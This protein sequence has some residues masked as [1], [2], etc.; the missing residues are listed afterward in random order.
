MEMNEH[1]FEPLQSGGFYCK[2]CKRNWARKPSYS[3]PGVEQFSWGQAPEYMKTERELHAMGLK[4]GG[5]P[6]GCVWWHKMRSYI[7]LYDSK[8]AVERP[9]ATKT[10]LAALEK[11]REALTCQGCGRRVVRKRHLYDGNCEYCATILWARK[12]LEDPNTRVMDTETTGLYSDAEIIEIAVLDAQGNVVLDTLVKPEGPIPAEAS[13]VNGIWD[14]MV[15]NAPRWA[16]IWP[17][18]IEAMRGKVVITYNVEFDRRM[19]TQTRKKYGI[20]EKL[21]VAGWTCL[22]E[23]YKDWVHSIRWFSL[24]SAC[25]HMGAQPGGHRAL[26]DAQAALG[27]L[28]AIA[29]RKLGREKEND[30][31]R[32]APAPAPSRPAG[33]G[34]LW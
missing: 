17:K 11:A 8:T 25:E 29:S 12:A 2:K 24:W 4:P 5:E 10:Q 6:V 26:G 22:M 28:R 18:V 3:C 32:W 13:N 1:E 20:E 21:G 27:L 19:V 33:D 16:E 9:K 23:T 15:A 7:Y 34:K 30:E 31:P 14:E